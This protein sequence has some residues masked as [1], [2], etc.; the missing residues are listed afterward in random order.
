[1][2]AT[3]AKQP[4]EVSVAAAC[5]GVVSGLVLLERD[6]PAP[7]VAI[8]S[9]MGSVAQETGQDPAEM[10]T[11]AMRGIAPVCVL[12]GA[13][14]CSAVEEAIEAKFMGAGAVFSAAC[15]ATKG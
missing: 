7:V 10:M 9:Q 5:K 6:L 1:V 13:D 12:A 8:L 3:S 11:W 2:G 15:A 4:P 14:K